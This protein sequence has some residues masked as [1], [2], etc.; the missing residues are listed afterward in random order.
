MTLIARFLWWSVLIRY[1]SY[2]DGLHKTCYV[3]YV[4]SIHSFQ[5]WRKDVKTYIIKIEENTSCLGNKYWKV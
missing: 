2:I 5:A 3:C 4:M 1:M